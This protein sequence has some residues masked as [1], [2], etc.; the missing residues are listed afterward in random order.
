MNAERKDFCKSLLRTVTHERR[1][2]YDNMMRMDWQKDP[3]SS[4]ALKCLVDCVSNIEIILEE[5]IND[6][7]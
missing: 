6:E 7:G 2:A 4:Y 3:E 5:L 1:G